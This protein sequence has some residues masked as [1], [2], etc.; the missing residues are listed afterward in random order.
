MAEERE[1]G[2]LIHPAV[3]FRVEIYTPERNAEFILSSAI[4]AVDYRSARE[5]VRKMGLDPD[6][7]KHQRPTKI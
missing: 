4:D 6:R 3:A 2:I 1:D 7:I 5:T